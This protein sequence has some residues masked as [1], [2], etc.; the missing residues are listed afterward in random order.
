MLAHELLRDEGILLI[1]PQGPIQAGDFESVAK[2]VDPYIENQR[3]LRGVMIEAQSFPGWDNFAAL[4]SHLRFVRDH[5]RLIT[6]IAAVSDST[7]LSLAPQIA[8]HFVKA[9]V[10]HFNANDREAALAWLRK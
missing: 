9:E 10:R 4:V 3:A 6:K 2:T 7:I 8:K 1:R 5:H